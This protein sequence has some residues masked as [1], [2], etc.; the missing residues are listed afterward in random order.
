MINALYPANL[1]VFMPNIDISNFYF[2]EIPTTDTFSHL[3]VAKSNTE[4]VTPN[5]LTYDMRFTIGRSEKSC[6][7]AL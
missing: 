3:S 6:Y 4:D 1:L 2:H 7:S 5:A